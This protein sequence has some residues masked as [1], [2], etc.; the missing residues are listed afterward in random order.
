MLGNG[1]EQFPG[2]FIEYQHF[3][4]RV[5]IACA[6][7]L[8]HLDH[9]I[10]CRLIDEGYHYVLRVNRIGSFLVLC[11]C[12]LCNFPYEIPSQPLW[13]GIAKLF[14]ICL[15]HIADFGRAHKR[16]RI[17]FAVQTAFAKKFWN[18]F[19]LL[20]RIEPKLAS[21]KAKAFI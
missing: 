16:E 21:S 2:G 1:I 7:L 3:A 8:K 15:I 14:Y 12:G 19:I 5:R 18:D 13:Q 9:H 17:E 6:P 20:W 4:F 10:V 11:G